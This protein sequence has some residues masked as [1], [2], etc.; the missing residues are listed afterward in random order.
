MGYLITSD[1]HEPWFCEKTDGF[2][3]YGEDYL[4]LFLSTTE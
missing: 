3:R 2:S 4:D 1:T